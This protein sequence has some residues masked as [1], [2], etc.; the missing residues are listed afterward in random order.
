MLGLRLGAAITASLTFVALWTPLASAQPPAG[1]TQSGRTLWEFEA[2]LQ[3]TF[4]H[5]LVSAHYNSGVNWEFAAC[6]NGCSP[7]AY[8]GSYVFT[9]SAARSSTFHLSD[10]RVVK[11][12][13]NYPTLI[14]VKRHPVACDRAETRFLIT[15][16]D[17]AGFAFACMHPGFVRP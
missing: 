12:F 11:D 10:K 16:G 3:D 17:A 2:L 15:Y 5:L 6:R 9:F 7:N 13:G 4:G 14:R 1:L 8:W